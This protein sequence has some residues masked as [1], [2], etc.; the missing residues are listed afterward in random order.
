MISV[1]EVPLYIQDVFP[2]YLVFGAGISS[3]YNTVHVTVVKNYGKLPLSV[4]IQHVGCRPEGISAYLVLI[5]DDKVVPCQ[6][7][8][9]GHA[10][11]RTWTNGPETA[12]CFAVLA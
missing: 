6:V 12:V 7:C 9:P 1:R 3:D 2:V 11:E 8:Q 4:Y 5:R 10:Q